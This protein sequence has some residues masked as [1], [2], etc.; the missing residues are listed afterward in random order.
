M[1]TCRDDADAQA[2]RRNPA[3]DRRGHIRP[4]PDVEDIVRCDIDNGIGRI[5]GCRRQT[6]GT[7]GRSIACLSM[8]TPEDSTENQADPK[9]RP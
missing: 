2:E 3:N 4:G 8:T 9:E 1:F 5:R 6:V 7:A